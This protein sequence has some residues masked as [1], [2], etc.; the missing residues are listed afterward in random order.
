MY[1]DAIHGLTVQCIEFERVSVGK[2]RTIMHGMNR[3]FI[4]LR[5]LALVDLTSLTMQLRC[6]GYV[7][8]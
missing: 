3:V 8:Q 4:R 6:N 1:M 2:G 5:G 7:V